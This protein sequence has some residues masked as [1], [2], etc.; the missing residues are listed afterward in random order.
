MTQRIPRVHLNPDNFLYACHSEDV[1]RTKKNG[2]FYSHLRY[3]PFLMDT[4]Q[5]PKS[6]QA[7]LLRKEILAIAKH[8]FQVS[9]Q[10]R[11]NEDVD[12]DT[13]SYFT[14]GIST[15][16]SDLNRIFFE[17]TGLGLPKIPS[18]DTEYSDSFPIVQKVI[19]QYTAYLAD[20]SAEKDPFEPF[21]ATAS[22]TK[23]EA[24]QEQNE[25]SA[26]IWDILSEITFEVFPNHAAAIMSYASWKFK[27][28][29]K[30]DPI[31]WRIRP[32]VGELFA[33]AFR[34]LRNGP[35]A[36]APRAGASAARSGGPGAK[37]QGGDKGHKPR[38]EGKHGVH[39]AHGD[40]PEQKISAPGEESGLSQEASQ[41]QLGSESPARP[42]RTDGPEIGPRGERSDSRPQRDIPER[43]PREDR[44]GRTERSEHRGRGDR[45]PGFQSQG[46]GRPAPAGQI[47]NDDDLTP[48]LEE[49]QAA[50]AQLEANPNLEEVK[51]N[52]S[53][54]F[55]RR[56]Q[57]SLL[58]ELGFETESRGEGRER[59]IYVRQKAH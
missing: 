36:G 22:R 3:E 9:P 25:F 41:S 6:P 14:L 31:D 46:R 4:F 56:H 11:R 40:L 38:R 39:A 23:D 29:E 50:V 32:P 10:F 26:E 57:H 30:P 54:S 12:L 16:F 55:I 33:K 49:A 5:R 45:E 2:T 15:L 21:L 7:A 24:A 34:S 51:L 58:V 1:A 27:M 37:P 59:C 35:G 42:R 43:G 47:Q 20:D 17:Y 48:Y 8:H 18:H 19:N 13:I 52:A 44:G 53:N 28:D